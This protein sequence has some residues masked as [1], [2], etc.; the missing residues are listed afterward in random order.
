MQTTIRVAFSAVRTVLLFEFKS[1]SLLMYPITQ[2]SSSFITA[3]PLAKTAHATHFERF[4]VGQH[5]F[6]WTS[7]Q[8]LLLRYAGQDR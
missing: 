4:S 5:G 6:F 1:T 3:R 7:Q 8:F 2:I